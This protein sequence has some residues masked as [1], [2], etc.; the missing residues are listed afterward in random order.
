MGLVPCSKLSAPSTLGPASPA[1]SSPPWSVS[2]RER[3]VSPV[4]NRLKGA[5]RGRGRGAHAD[6]RGI[7]AIQSGDNPRTVSETHVPT[8]RRP[9]RGRRERRRANL[10]LAEPPTKAV[11]RSTGTSMSRSAQAPGR[12]REAHSDER[13][14]LT[15]ADMITLL[16]ALFYGPFSISSVNKSKFERC[17]TRSR[18]PSTAPL[19]GGQAIKEAGGSDRDE[20]RSCR[21]LRTSPSSQPGREGQDNAKKGARPRPGLQEGKIRVDKL[22]AKRA[23][24]RAPHDRHAPGLDVRILSA[25]P[26]VRVGLRGSDPRPPGLL[27]GLGDILNEEGPR[28]R[29]PSRA[30]PTQPISTGRS[31]PTGSSR[32]TCL[33]IVRSFLVDGPTSTV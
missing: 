19:P 13:W 27:A 31:R 1:R 15:Y 20:S 17:R 26:A 10:K 16:M 32:R 11:A 4:A 21:R 33:A 23:C 7:L 2:A 22:A 28:T 18:T 5:R 9:M 24:R 30:T 14:L 12:A 6:P 3:R 25:R 29:H 8:C